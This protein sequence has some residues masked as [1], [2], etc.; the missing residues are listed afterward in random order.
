MKAIDDLAAGV[1]PPQVEVEAGDMPEIISKVESKDKPNWRDSEYSDG[2]LP[3]L[4]F[5][6]DS[7]T[8]PHK[9]SRKI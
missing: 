4:V 5:P 2:S 8:F 6:D 7:S 3:L 9:C 1:S